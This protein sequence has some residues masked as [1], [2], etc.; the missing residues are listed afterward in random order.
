MKN[1]RNSYQ[2][3]AAGKKFMEGE[4]VTPPSSPAKKIKKKIDKS[5]AKK[6]KAST[7]KSTPKKAKAGKK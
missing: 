7:K 1:K 5:P 2:L 4:V 6:G 3:A